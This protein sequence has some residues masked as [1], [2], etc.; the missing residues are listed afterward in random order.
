MKKSKILLTYNE[1][2][3]ILES[4]L[5]C[6]ICDDDGVKRLHSEGKTN[7]LMCKEEAYEYFIM[8]P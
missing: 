2:R 1:W 6:K 4:Q 5:D 3:P 8:L 7:N